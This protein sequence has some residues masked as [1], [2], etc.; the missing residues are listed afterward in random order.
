MH[1]ACTLYTHV[2]HYIYAQLHISVRHVGACM[3]INYIICVYTSISDQCIHG[4]MHGFYK[5]VRIAIPAW[6]VY[7]T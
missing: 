5:Y 4:S 6:G 2:A 7:I 3:Y 1:T